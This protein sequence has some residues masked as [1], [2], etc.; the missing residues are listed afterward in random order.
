M[1]H[2][3]RSAAILHGF[4]GHR[5]LSIFARGTNLRT[6]FHG[7]PSKGEGTLISFRV[8]NGFKKVHGLWKYEGM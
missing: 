8:S 1:A 5:F 3:I 4:S 2:G 7:K 6:T